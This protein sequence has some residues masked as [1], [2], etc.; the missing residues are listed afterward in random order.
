MTTAIGTSA[1]LASFEEIMTAPKPGLVDPLGSGCHDD[2]EWGVSLRSASVLAPFWAEQAAEGIRHSDDEALMSALRARG[3]EME[4]AMFDTT[5]GVNTHKGLIFALSLLAA[6]AGSCLQTGDGSPANICRRA[7]EIAAPCCAAEF[8]AIRSRGAT[9]NA[10]HGEAIYLRYGVGGIRKEAMNGFPTPLR[11]GLPAL[12]AALEAG[13]APGDAALAALLALMAHCEDTNIIHRAGYDFWRVSYKK[14]AS[15][16]SARFNPLKPG[17]YG[18]LTELESLLLAHRASPG[19]AADLLT[20]TL[21]LYRSKITDNI[22]SKE[23]VL[24]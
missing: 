13:C 14:T 18:A 4:R 9:G 6:A 19:G 7:G 16:A 11:Y 2:M 10:T 1:A 20:C 22:F 17:R 5:G 23:E 8:E 24:L 12:E 3:L 21:F 15:D